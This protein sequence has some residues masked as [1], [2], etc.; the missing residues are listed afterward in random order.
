MTFF[1]QFYLVINEQ[2]NSERSAHISI[3]NLTDVKSLKDAVAYIT[4]LN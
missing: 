3:E 4:L 2:E 1:Y